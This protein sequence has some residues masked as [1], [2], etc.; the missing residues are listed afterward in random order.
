MLQLPWLKLAEAL[1]QICPETSLTLSTI[2]SDQTAS[3][4]SELNLNLHFSIYSLYGNINSLIVVSWCVICQIMRWQEIQPKYEVTRTTLF[5][6]DDTSLFIMCV[7]FASSLS[8]YCFLTKCSIHVV[9]MGSPGYLW[10]T[11]SDAHSVQN[12]MVEELAKY[13]NQHISH[14]SGK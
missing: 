8:G 5:D 1:K 7:V 2:F 12:E 3:G 14:I 13:K 4:F 10:S 11:S 9:D 6:S